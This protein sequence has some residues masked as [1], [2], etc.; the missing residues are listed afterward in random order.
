MHAN[1][2][3]LASLICLWATPSFAAGDSRF[4][5][6]NS[7]ARYL[8]HIDLYDVNN[9]KITADSDQPYSTRNTCGRCH[10]FETI[11]HGWHFNAFANEIH[12]G[13]ISEPWIW[14]DMRT[15]TQ[16]PLSY[17]GGAGRFHPDEVGITR[18]EMTQ[19]F[20]ARLPGGG[21]GDITTSASADAND[22]SGLSPRWQFTGS[23]EVDCM[24]C[25][26]V[27]GAYDFQSRRE[28]I[29]DEN[30]AWA[31]TVGLRLGAVSGRVGSIRDGSD[32][33]DER[34]R[35]R[36][37][38]V[39]YDPQRFGS[40]GTVF[41]DLVR[42]PTNNACYQCHSMRQVNDEGIEARWIH[43]NDVHLIAGMNCVDCH[44]NGI[45]H[46]IVRGYAGEQNPSGVDVATLS[47]QGCHLGTEAPATSADT[48]I[49]FVSIVQRAGRLGSPTPK[50]EGL[51]P[52]HFEKLSCTA[53]H[54]GPTPGE[55]TKR[56]MTSLGHGLGKKDHLSGNE[57]PMIAGPIYAAVPDQ[58]DA[59]V[60]P[61]RATWPAYWG[62]IQ[63]D[64]I[65]PLPPERVYQST[66]RA[67][68]VRKNF[69]DEVILKDP[70]DPQFDAKV[71]AALA[72]LESEFEVEQAAY[73]S[74]GRIY[75]RG[76]EDATLTT[77]TV[78]NVDAVEMIR[79]PMAHNVRPANWSLGATGCLECHSNDGLIFA[80]TVIP[81]G[82]AITETDPITMASLQGIDETDRD[83]WNQLFAGRK[84][85]KF[86]TAASLL[87]L[88]IMSLVGFG[89]QIV[90]LYRGSGD[91]HAASA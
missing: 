26:A 24:V 69:I 60:T 8:H 33:D 49:S 30:F 1:R 90:R 3:W 6:S 72:A 15:G 81:S 9:R 5:H 38:K 35:A 55:T 50:H 47:C 66:R 85:F 41:M 11:S 43:D 29:E 28:A 74:T 14:T 79:W 46:H 23:L 22:S 63:D 10:D 16:L 83:R 18:F 44:R 36:L 65:E 13:R 37:P 20:G 12:S 27:S 39:A 73:V 61:Q 25:H 68:R 19:Q 54:G 87:V 52:L 34:V 4:A 2:I 32:P 82:P 51:P 40:D 89:W 45:D 57:M 56:L 58:S 53:C 64:I 7:N 62:R 70:D 77:R 88:L 21:L 17:R 75:V 71:S 59:A 80:S 67:L 84:Q 48:E 76:D 78:A 31:P 86:L 42:M 91:Q